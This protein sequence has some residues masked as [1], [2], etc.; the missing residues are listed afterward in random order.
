[1][2]SLSGEYGEEVNRCADLYLTYRDLVT[3]RSI[4]S[5]E[6]AVVVW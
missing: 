1:M 2:M 4:G 3:E 5:L 6:V